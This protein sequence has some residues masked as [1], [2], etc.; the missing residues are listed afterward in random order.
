MRKTQHGYTTDKHMVHMYDGLAANTIATTETE[1]VGTLVDG[2]LGVE[3]DVAT[4][5]DAARLDFYYVLWTRFMPFE[6]HR[7]RIDIRR[8]KELRQLRNLRG[9]NP[10][11]LP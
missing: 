5:S 7:P 3:D 1:I 11:L 2:N 10:S 9:W 4:V 8:D 6:Q